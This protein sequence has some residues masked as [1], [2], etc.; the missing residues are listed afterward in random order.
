MTS[1]TALFSDAVAYLIAG[2]SEEPME[3]P[4][5]CASSGAHRLQTTT[6]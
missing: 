6:T 2:S 3:R 5:R 1:D 4:A